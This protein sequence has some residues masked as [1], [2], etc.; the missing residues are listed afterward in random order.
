MKNGVPL[1][2]NEKRWDS[3]EVSE[4]SNVEVRGWDLRGAT[5]NA[6]NFIIDCF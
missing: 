2:M 5:G 6:M 4:I 1:A 3:A